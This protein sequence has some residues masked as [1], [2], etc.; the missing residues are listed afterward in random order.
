MGLPNFYH[1]KLS[2]GWGGTRVVHNIQLAE[3]IVPSKDVDFIS[4]GAC[5]GDSTTVRSATK[6]VW[7]HF[8]SVPVKRVSQS[9]IRWTLKQ[10]DEVLL[11]IDQWVLFVWIELS[12]HPSLSFDC[13]A[14]LN[15]IHPED[16]KGLV[17]ALRL[18][19]KSLSGARK[20]KKRWSDTRIQ[21]KVQQE[22]RN[23]K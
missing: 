23:S 17:F 10:K 21:R 18:Q 9:L 3:L 15:G 12:F 14:F 22:K 13:E 16:P 4:E 6:C 5:F 1:P 2:W 11:E 8:P 20:M 19:R 7:Q